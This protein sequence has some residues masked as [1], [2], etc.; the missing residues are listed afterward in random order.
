MQESEKHLLRSALRQRRQNLP[1]DA[2]REDSARIVACLLAMERISRARSAML[3]LPAKG[4]VDTWPLLEHF[5]S[6]GGEVLLPRCRRG[7]PGIMDA[8]AVASRADLAPGR[9][10]L[11]EPRADL[12]RRVPAPAPEIV[13]VPALA[14]DRNGNRLGFGG[15][16]YDR[17]LPTLAGG[18][19]LVGLAYAFQLLDSVPVEPW[20]C[21]VHAVVTP[22]EIIHVNTKGRT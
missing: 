17:F 2:V 6:R 4:E 10:G 19:W 11:T 1:A 7:S 18:P 9:F 14:F 3:Y 5:W 15:G 20:D 8:I 21:P 12:P 16:Y 13:L 22:E